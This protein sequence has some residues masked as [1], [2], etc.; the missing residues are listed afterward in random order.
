MNGG[1]RHVTTTITVCDTCKR[2]GFDP[3]TDGL[4]DGARLLEMVRTAAEGNETVRVR[5]T[6]CL[7]GCDYACNVAVQGMGK[8]GYAI[9]TFEAAPDQAQA[10]VD[11]AAL[12]AASE[13][14]QVPYKTWPAEIKGHFRARLFPLD[15]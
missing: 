13:T 12:H 6:S 1:N 14:G 11:W 10:I 7:M 5:S 15:E 9:G 3:E 4:P 8:I 2:A